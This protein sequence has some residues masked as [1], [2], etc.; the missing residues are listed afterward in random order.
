VE[1][2]N[3]NMFDYLQ[4]NKDIT[5]YSNFKTP[6]KAKYFYELL[7]E[8]DINKVYE[9]YVWAKKENL[10]FLI[11]G[12]GTNMLFA[13]DEFPWIIIKNSLYGWEYNEKTHILES[14][15]NEPIWEI[16]EV[17]EKD[18][19]QFLWHRFIGLPWS[20][21]GAVYGNAGCFGLEV[22]NHFLSAKVLDFETWEVLVFTS[23]MMDFE[24]RSTIFKKTGRYFIISIQFD[25][26]EKREK[27]HSDV[28]NIH[29]REH[30]QPKGN[31]CGSF[32]KNPSRE[33][34]AWYLIE[35]VGLKWYKHGGAYFSEKH[36]NFL[37]HDGSGTYKDLLHLIHLAQEKVQADFDIQLENEVRIIDIT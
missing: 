20:I 37:M 2:N 31:S 25:L 5:N 33:F 26:S 18:D 32:F 9:L 13:F 6:A 3:E 8:E 29:F 19:G 30:K 12:G 16:A 36:A 15:S 22:E 35:Q 7:D 28:D 24:Y 17:L 27:Y 1:Y 11:I 21:G 14:Y 4:K 10:P 23:D 34:S